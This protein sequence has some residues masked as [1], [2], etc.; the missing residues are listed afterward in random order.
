MADSSLDKE[1]YN[2]LGEEDAPNVLIEYASL[3]CVHCADFHT[4]RLPPIK[5]KLIDNGKLKYIYKDF[6]LDLPAMLASMVSNCYSGIQ[7]F[8]IL[9][10][11]FRNQKKWVTSSENKKELYSSLHLILKEHGVT[12]AKITACTEESEDNKKKWNIILATRLAGQKKGVSSTPTFFLNGKKLEG[13]VD[14]K[15]IEEHIY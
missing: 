12:L 10:S 15:K 14:L 7:Y 6:P 3:S 9:N 11:L 1:K 8:E 2:Y 13:L 4:K 5:T